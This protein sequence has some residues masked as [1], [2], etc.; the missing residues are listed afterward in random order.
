MIFLLSE[1]F[2]YR[3]FFEIVLIWV[4]NAVVERREIIDI[5]L[6]NN[7]QFSM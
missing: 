4:D 7:S 6:K 5:L 1:V 3:F 2:F